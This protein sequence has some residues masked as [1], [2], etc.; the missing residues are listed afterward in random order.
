MED[1]NTGIMGTKEKKKDVFTS[2]H[3]SNVPIF[4]K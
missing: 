3:F 1:W 2:F 4:Q